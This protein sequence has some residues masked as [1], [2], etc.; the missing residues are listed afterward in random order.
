MLPGVKDPKLLTRRAGQLADIFTASLPVEGTLTPQE[1]QVS[2]SIGISIAPKDGTEYADLLR[3]ADIALYTAKRAGKS[4][5]RFFEPEM[6]KT[7]AGSVLSEI[8]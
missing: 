6:L 2:G 4:T 5:W 8:D 3:K 1:Y 7:T